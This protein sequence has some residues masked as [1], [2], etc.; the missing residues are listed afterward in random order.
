M[1]STLPI[2]VLLL[3][4]YTAPVRAK[5]PCG[6]LPIPTSK[7]YQGEARKKHFLGYS[8]DWTCSYSCTRDGGQGDGPTVMVKASYHE[9]YLRPENGTEGVCE[10]MVYKS[11]YHP[12][13]N[14]IVY[15]YMG[16]NFSFS[17][18]DSSSKD[19]QRWANANN[20]D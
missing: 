6:C 2:L 20:C 4:A 14:E 5:N 1:R 18:T 9:F 15:M 11:H 7:T 10:G 17:P 12:V 19:L 16:E 13:R 8:I 3:S